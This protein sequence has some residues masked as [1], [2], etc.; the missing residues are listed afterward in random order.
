ME[1]ALGTKKQS[2][3]SLNPYYN[4]RYSWRFSN[5][6]KGLL[7]TGLNPYYNGRYSWSFMQNI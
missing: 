6:T 3:Y 7:Q 4:G 1:T 2:I 5:N